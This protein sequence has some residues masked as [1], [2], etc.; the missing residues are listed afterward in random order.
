M[1]RRTPVHRL[2]A[3]GALRQQ[4][5]AGRGSTVMSTASIGHPKDTVKRDLRQVVVYGAAS[6]ID[7]PL[8]VNF[9][10]THYRLRTQAY[11]PALMHA[12]SR[13]SAAFAKVH[14]LASRSALPV[15]TVMVRS[16]G[17]VTAMQACPAASP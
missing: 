8:N 5:K 11:L 3:N 16:T 1:D 17:P 12:S 9:K 4:L 10:L 2:K 14:M 6:W 7:H 15:S 13:S